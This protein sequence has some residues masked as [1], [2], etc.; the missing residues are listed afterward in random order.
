VSADTRPSLRPLLFDEGDPI[1]KL[2]RNAPRERE[3]A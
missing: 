2:G 3:V 1:A